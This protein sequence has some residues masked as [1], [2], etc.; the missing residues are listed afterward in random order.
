MA[1]GKPGSATPTPF[2]PRQSVKYVR[3]RLAVN[4]APQRQ[5]HRANRLDIFTDSLAGGVR[6]R[7]AP[8]SRAPEGSR[9]QGCEPLKH[10]RGKG[11]ALIG[12]GMIR[13]QV[14]CPEP[15]IARF[16][17]GSGKTRCL[18]AQGRLRTLRRGPAGSLAHPFWIQNSISAA[19]AMVSRASPSGV[20]PDRGAMP[21]RA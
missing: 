13:R 1:T 20:Q 9:W 18:P 10:C 7:P 17:Q 5:P 14:K 4:R 16:A 8:D 3:I 15:G 21:S 11:D 12:I 19:L 2:H 6:F